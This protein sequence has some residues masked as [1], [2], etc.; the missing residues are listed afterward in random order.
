MERGL[1]F[2]SGRTS[3]EM[4][5]K[6]ARAGI[7]DLAGVGA[8]SALAVALGEKLNMFVAGLVREGTMIIYSGRSALRG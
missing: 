2:L 4:A 6:A 3:F 8:P 5:A 7:G 1:M